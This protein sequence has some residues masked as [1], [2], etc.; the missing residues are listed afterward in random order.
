MAIPFPS[1][2]N[3][4]YLHHDV[5]SGGLWRYIGGDPRSEQNWLLV[6]GELIG[7]PDTS[8]WGVK[9]AGSRWYNKTLGGFFG[10]NGSVVNLLSTVSQAIIVP[11][12][13]SD[14]LVGQ[15]VIDRGPNVNLTLT[16]AFQTIPDILVTVVG[17]GGI[18][19]IR[20]VIAVK[21]NGAITTFSARLIKNGVVVVGTLRT[22][23]AP[24]IATVGVG[25][26]YFIPVEYVDNVAVVGDTYQVQAASNPAPGNTNAQSGYCMLEA[27]TRTTGMTLTTNPIAD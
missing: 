12:G 24:N 9:Q 25:S 1:S 3:P 14:V 18:V 13:S 15:V 16:V 5:V 22:W 11:V 7:H 19:R 6:G 10:W 4:G 8:A 20:G 2:V 26:I 27:E 21:N 17:I 23:D